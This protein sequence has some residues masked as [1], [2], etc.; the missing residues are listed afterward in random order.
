M[1]SFMN[2][3]TQNSLSK[4]LAR[5]FATVPVLKNYINGEWVASKSTTHFEITNP[6]T[7]ELLSLVPETLDSEFDHAA[8]SAQEAYNT[9]RNIP[10][11]TRQRYMFDYIVLL[12]ENKVLIYN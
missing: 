2:S 6:A 4:I 1:K 7:Q 8:K 10:I 11:T 5:R 9:W 12:R 3:K